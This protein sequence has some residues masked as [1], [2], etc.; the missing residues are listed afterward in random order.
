MKGR[1][2]IEL[3]PGMHRGF[4]RGIK[5]A[6]DLITLTDYKKLRAE[7]KK[8]IGGQTNSKM[9]YYING[10]TVIREDVAKKIERIFSK[11]G[12]T[13]GELWDA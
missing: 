1:T 4:K 10:K 5:A 2:K 8:V 7:L 6:S 11:R 13:P 12:I 3:K 9:Q